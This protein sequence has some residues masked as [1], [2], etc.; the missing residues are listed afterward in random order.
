[1]YCSI[2][3]YAVRNTGMRVYTTKLGEI[4]YTMIMDM[5]N[6]PQAQPPF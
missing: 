6:L 4:R 5:R 1:M 3:G 2:Q